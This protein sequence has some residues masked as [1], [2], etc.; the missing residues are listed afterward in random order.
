[1]RCWVRTCTMMA[2]QGITACPA[3]SFRSLYTRQR[4]QRINS[5]DLGSPGAPLLAAAG[6]FRANQGMRACG[7]PL[8][9][10][11]ITAPH[12]GEQVSST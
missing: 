6:C 1:M 8:G 7:T 3:F 9:P 2:C 4:I 5:C 12:S 11:A 10:T